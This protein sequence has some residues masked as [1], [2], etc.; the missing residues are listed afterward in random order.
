M[1]YS[2]K[3]KNQSEILNSLLRKIKKSQKEEKILG[4][5]ALQKLYQEDGFNFL[6]F[7]SELALFVNEFFEDEDIADEL[8]SL[9]KIHFDLTGKRLL[10]NP[11]E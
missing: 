8:N 1:F 3:S 9:L 2:K 5:K 6:N 11:I 10:K 4:L 7:D